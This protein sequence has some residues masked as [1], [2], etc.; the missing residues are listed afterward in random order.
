[1]RDASGQMYTRNRCYDPATGQ[2][3]QTDPIGLAGGLNGYGFAE[4]G[5]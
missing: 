5:C 3:R 2:F 4:G 1:M